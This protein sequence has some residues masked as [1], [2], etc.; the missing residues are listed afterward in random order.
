MMLIQH[1]ISMNCLSCL[2]RVNDGDDDDGGGSCSELAEAEQMMQL[3][4][5]GWVLNAD[6]DDGVEVVGS[7]PDQANGYWIRNAGLWCCVGDRDPLCLS[8]SWLH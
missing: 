8:S 1:L 7:F 6:G 2:G 3:V 5:I 4:D